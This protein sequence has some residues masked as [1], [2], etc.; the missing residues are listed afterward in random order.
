LS[1]YRRGGNPSS[2]H[3]SSPIPLSCPASPP[4]GSSHPS[5]H[6]HLSNSHSPSW[7]V[8]SRYISLG[9]GVSERGGRRERKRQKRTTMKVMV[10]FR[11][12]LAGFLLFSLFLLVISPVLLLIVSPVF[13][14]RSR[15]SSCC[16]S[17]HS[18]RHSSCSSCIIH[19]VVHC[20]RHL[21]SA[22]SLFEGEGGCR[23]FSGPGALAIGPTSLKRGKGHH[24]L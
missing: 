18:S 2:S 7:V 3:P 8:F 6:I 1:S 4:S 22:I 23:Y 10:R 17:R 11:H 5:S 12:A 16:S 21:Q 19:P 13:I 14:V 20:P 24:A 9:L 15:C